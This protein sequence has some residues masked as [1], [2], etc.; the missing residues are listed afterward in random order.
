MTTR[1]NKRQILFLII[2]AIV[3]MTVLSY[4]PIVHNGFVNYDDNQYVF[5][6]PNVKGGITQRSIIWAF[7]NLNI[8]YWHPLTWLS[9]MLDCEIYG[10]RPLGHHITSILIHI[11]NSV[12]L[13]LLLSKMTGTVWRSGFVAAAFALHPV[14]VESVAW[15]AERKDVLS[16]LFWILSMLAY[17]HY[18]ERPNVRRY[19][20]VLLTFVM[21]LMSKPMMVTLP[22]ALLLL[23]YW[24]LDRFIL[25]QDKTSSP[26]DISIIC[27]KASVWRLLEEKVPMFVL[28]AALS[29]I[30]FV[31]QKQVGVVASLEAMPLHIRAV[32]SLGSYYHYIM[33]MLCPKALAVLYPPPT[34]MTTD[35]AAMAVMGVAVLLVLW[36][37]GRRWLVVGLLWYLG[38]LVPVIG[39]VQSGF[40]IMA[41]RYTYIPS[42]GVFIIIAWG[43]AEIF[44]KLSHPKHAAAAAGA[45]VLIVMVLMTQNQVRYWRDSATL[46]EHAIAVTKNNYTIHYNYGLDLFEQGQYDKALQHFKEAGR[47]YPKYLAA[48]N[49]ICIT[50]LAQKKLDEAIS[51]FS[52]ALKERNDWPEIHMMYYNLGVAYEQK[53]DFAHAAINYR[54]ALT[55]NPD[56]VL[57]QQGLTYLQA[58]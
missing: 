8:S 57:A 19:A 20:I 21:G 22:F 53:G 12:L 43:A 6:N 40:Q 30:T 11:I 25:Q 13:F 56:F 54:K 23:D 28:S 33:K 46:F 29:V 49:S 1:F 10:L 2:A 36:G 26:A 14:H 52:D 35:A 15:V 18:A 55:L 48:R 3:A 4:A 42:I 58:K 16:G 34:Q 37:R 24:P 41:D 17:V 7:T 50:L 44:A 38:T 31:A 51:C 39:L 9:H 5:N 27:Q 32:N 47:I 45:A